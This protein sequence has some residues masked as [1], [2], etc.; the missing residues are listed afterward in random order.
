MLDHSA[1]KQRL[2]H[3]GNYFRFDFGLEAG[4]KG[5][6]SST[7][8]LAISISRPTL[9]TLRI[10]A[11]LISSRPHVRNYLDSLLTSR[12]IGPL[13]DGVVLKSSA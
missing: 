4:D 13:R 1:T 11:A 9:W 10:S 3:R 2:K 8:K 12:N 7:V 6:A 5:T